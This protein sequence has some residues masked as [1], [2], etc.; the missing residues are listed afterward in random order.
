VATTGLAVHANG[1][2]ARAPQCLLLAVTP[3]LEPWSR[4]KIL[5][6][7]DGARDLAR[8]RL[9]TL[10][11]LPLAATVLPAARVAHWSL[12][13]EPVIDPRWLSTVADPSAVPSFVTFAD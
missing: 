3:D 8:I 9:V 11:R 10:E 12:Q 1:P 13:G 6:V 2:G 4:E 5:A 7:V